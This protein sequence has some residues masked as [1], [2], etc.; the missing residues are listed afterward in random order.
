MTSPEGHDE[1]EEFEVIIPSDTSKG[2]AV[3]ERIVKALEDRSFSPRDVFGVRLALEEAIVNAIKHGN[4]MDPKK[5]VRICCTVNHNK[6]RVEVEDQGIGFKVA[7]VPDPT[8]DENLERPCGRGIMLMKAF[9]NL[10]EYNESGNMIVL[11]K[12]RDLDPEGDD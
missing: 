2:Q 12:I 8:L 6:V 5:S 10:I 1:I 11:E 9:M 3:Q 7:D 4:R